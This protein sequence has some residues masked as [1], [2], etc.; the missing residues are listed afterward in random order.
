[1]SRLIYHKNNF[2]YFHFPFVLQTKILSNHYPLGV[3]VIICLTDYLM[4]AVVDPPRY[5]EH[6][7][8]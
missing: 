7:V 1:M 5:S 3:Q 4:K 6:R 8:M 2:D